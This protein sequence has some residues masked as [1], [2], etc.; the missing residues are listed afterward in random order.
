MASLLDIYRLHIWKFISCFYF[1]FCPDYQLLEHSSAMLGHIKNKFFWH[2]FYGE[3]TIWDWCAWILNSN[4]HCSLVFSAQY[5][6]FIGASPG[7]SGLVHLWY[8]VV[9]CP[10]QLRSNFF[11]WQCIL[12]PCFYLWLMQAAHPHL[13]WLWLWTFW[14]T[15]PL[16]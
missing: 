3:F 15:A 2:D 6:V 9:S 16:D 5:V 13:Q 14:Q 11:F 8:L 1:C 10:F 7:I 12:Q 4:P